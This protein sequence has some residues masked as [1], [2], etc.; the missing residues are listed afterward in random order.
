MV[1]MVLII[2]SLLAA[3]AIEAGS[4]EMKISHNEFKAQQ[5]QQ[6]A[7]AGVEWGAERI[8]LYLLSYQADAELPV[9][10]DFQPDSK[11]QRFGTDLLDPDSPNFMINNWQ[12][13]RVSGAVSNPAVYQFT[14]TGNYLN[15][16][17]K[18]EV[19]I[20]YPYVGGTID[21]ITGNFQERNY[22]QSRGVISCYKVCY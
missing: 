9:C 4:L 12:A 3:A 6:S 1:L 13:V 18:I 11:P 21:P 17:K 10:I 19:Q 7:D 16:N 14:S 8:Y 2:V 22:S 5:A 20:S 15:T